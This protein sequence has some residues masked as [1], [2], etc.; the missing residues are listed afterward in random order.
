MIENNILLK[1]ILTLKSIAEFPP[2]LYGVRSIKVAKHLKHIEHVDVYRFARQP[3][4]G[5]VFLV[6][7]ICTKT[8]YSQLVQYE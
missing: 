6:A 3:P 1:L 5:N 4:K 7:C 8:R 2:V